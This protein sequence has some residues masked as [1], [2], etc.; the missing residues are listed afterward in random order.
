MITV[1]ACKC[2]FCGDIVYIRHSNETC[3]TCTCGGSFATP[4]GGFNNHSI[5]KCAETIVLML[6]VENRQVLEKDYTSGENKYG[7][8]K[9]G[10]KSKI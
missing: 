4:D 6:D 9:K 1:V 8:L 5:M 2:H 7:L 3:R 10:F